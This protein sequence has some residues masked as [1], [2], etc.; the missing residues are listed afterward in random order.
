MLLAA[1]IKR[2]ND[3]VK[4]LQGALLQT[5]EDYV[6]LKIVSK[7][8]I[9]SLKREIEMTKELLDNLFPREQMSELEVEECHKVAIEFQANIEVSQS[10]YDRI[11][12]GYKERI[13]KV[14]EEIQTYNDLVHY[15]MQKVGSQADS[16][17]GARPESEVVNY[18]ADWSDKRL[19]Q[20]TSGRGF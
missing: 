18:A 16:I 10:E 9:A 20:K 7:A 15:F 11:S 17:E 6:E 1:L 19:R 4:E 3:K 13:V 5:A 8:E 12:S 14:D 2:F